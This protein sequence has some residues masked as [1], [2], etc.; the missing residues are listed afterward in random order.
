MSSLSPPSGGDQNQG[1][2]ILIVEWVLTAVALIVV[3]ARIFGRIRITRNLGLDDLWI[4]I[5]MVLYF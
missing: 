2:R 1:P 4:I 5:A 3:G